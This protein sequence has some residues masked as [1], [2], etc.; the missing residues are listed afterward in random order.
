[1]GPKV[2]STKRARD[3]ASCID[4]SQ[5]CEISKISSNTV[6][7]REQQADHEDD[8]CSEGSKLSGSALRKFL[9][10]NFFDF[11]DEECA[12][13]SEIAGACVDSS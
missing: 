6:R 9:Q 1:M 5:P 13:I 8:L 3:E 10:K 7:E 11:A 4:D 2:K 12:K